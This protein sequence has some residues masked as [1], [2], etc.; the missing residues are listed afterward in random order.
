MHGIDDDIETVNG[1]FQDIDIPTVKPA[2]NEQQALSKALKYVG[3]QKYKWED[4][5]MENFIKQ[6]RGL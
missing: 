1:D 3:A 2:I 5:D 6:Q 4:S